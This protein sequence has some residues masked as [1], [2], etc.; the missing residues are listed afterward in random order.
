VGV[1]KQMEII[2]SDCI[3]DEDIEYELQVELSI[4]LQRI[5]E[6]FAA[7]VLSIQQSRPFDAV[8]IIVPGCICAIAD[9]IIRRRAIDLPSEVCTHLMGQTRDG[10]QLGIPGFGLSVTTFAQQTENIEIHLPEL[11]VAQ[12][13]ILDYF[14][15]PQQSK[16]HKIFS[17]EN[18]HSLK[19]NRS[20]I[21]YLRNICHEIASGEPAPHKLLLDTLPDSSLLMK[22]YPE[23]RC[24]RDIS[25]IGNIFLI[26][27]ELPLL[28]I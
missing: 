4:T 11:C 22:N 17:W 13:A 1:E 20:L 26:Q 14:Q 3:W 19:P 6:H 16:L 12:T 28:I 10:K 15:S 27:I 2:K 24:L 25:F 5:M 18:S 23:L 8:C 21:K 9:S 7:S